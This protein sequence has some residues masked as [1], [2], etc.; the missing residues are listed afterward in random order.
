MRGAWRVVGSL[1]SDCIIGVRIEISHLPLEAFPL[2][3]EMSAQQTKGLAVCGE[4]KGDRLR[5]MR[6][7]ASYYQ[8]LKAI[9]GDRHLIRHFVTPSPQGEGFRF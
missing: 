7:V 1:R 4:Q 9:K 2:T 8:L 5:W 3:G 6:C